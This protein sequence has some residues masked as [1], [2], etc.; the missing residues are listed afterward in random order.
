MNGAVAVYF[1]PAAVIVVLVLLGQVLELRARSR[2]SSAIRNLLGLAPKNARRIGPDGTEQDVPLG[3]VRVRD[4]LR[5]RPGR[6]DSC[7][8]RGSDG[9]TT[10][11]NRWSPVSRSGREDGWQQSH[12]RHRERQPARS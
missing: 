1:E 11:T 3:D 2:T 5:V 6:A 10:S 9:K 7:R 4:R 12:G 8:R